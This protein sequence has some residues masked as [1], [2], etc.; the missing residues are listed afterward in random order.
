MILDKKS[1]ILVQIQKRAIIAPT[2][3]IDDITLECV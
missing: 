1:A 2:V 3:K